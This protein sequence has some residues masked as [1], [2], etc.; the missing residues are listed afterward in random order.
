MDYTMRE[1]QYHIVTLREVQIK[2]QY[3]GVPVMA[4]CNESDQYP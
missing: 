4:Q 2:K 1:I 3:Y